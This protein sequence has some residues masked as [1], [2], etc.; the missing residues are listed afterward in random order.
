MELTSIEVDFLF[1]LLV[2]ILGRAILNQ[3]FSTAKINPNWDFMKFSFARG[4]CTGDFEVKYTKN[5]GYSLVLHL[6]IVVIHFYFLL[7]SV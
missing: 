4:L 6:V 7:K 1:V 2:F 5:K 3:L